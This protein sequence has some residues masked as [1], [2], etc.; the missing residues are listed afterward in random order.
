MPQRN[1]ILDEPIILFSDLDALRIRN[2]IDNGT[3]VIGG[4]GAG[5]SSTSSKALA[6]ALVRAQLRDGGEEQTRESA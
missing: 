4:P 3:L 2:L 6:R 5:K 1:R